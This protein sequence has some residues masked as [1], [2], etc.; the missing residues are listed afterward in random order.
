MTSFT[1][2]VSQVGLSCNLWLHF[3]PLPHPV[4]GC[5]LA[6][7]R[8]HWHEGQ[9]AKAQC[10]SL[11]RLLAEAYELINMV[12]LQHVRL[13][14]YNKFRRS[15]LS[16]TQVV[17]HLQLQC[18]VSLRYTTGPVLEHIN[19]TPNVQ[20]ESCTSKSKS[21]PLLWV[22][23]FLYT[24]TQHLQVKS[25]MPALYGDPRRNREPQDS[26]E[27]R[28]TEK[29]SLHGPG[30]WSPQHNQQ[31]LH[32]LEIGDGDPGRDAEGSRSSAAAARNEAAEDAAAGQ[33][34]EPSGR[35]GAEETVAARIT[36]ALGGGGS[37][38]AV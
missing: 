10:A 34:G 31:S 17:H 7:D 15:S 5:V 3:Q 33:F 2:E 37:L 29:S 30:K 6:A 22:G 28:E 25:L 36:G 32:P 4:V 27:Q 23:T 35:G 18:L 26:G 1:T 14:C 19:G 11:E 9:K 38:V 13:A 12:E 24:A 21:D 20:N 16:V 8:R